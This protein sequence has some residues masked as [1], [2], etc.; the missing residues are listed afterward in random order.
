MPSLIIH[1]HFYQ[2]PREN[3]WTGIVETEPDAAPYHDWNE[4]V[5][6]EC[7]GPNAAVK[8]NPHEV[9]NNYANLSF[10]FGPT[11]LSWLEREHP[12]TYSQ[13]IAADAQSAQRHNGHGNAIAHAYNHPILPLCNDRDLNTQIR[14]GLADFRYRFGRA[15]EAMW[16]PETACNDGVLEALIEH[17]LR[18][19]ILAPQQATHV[20]NTN[21]EWQDVSVANLDTSRAYRWPHRTNNEKFIS[22]FFYDADVAHA[23]AFEQALSS[24]EALAGLMKQKIGAR[25]MLNVATDGESY[26]HHHKFGDLALAHLTAHAAI[27]RGLT[28][29]NYAEFLDR[30]PATIEVKISNGPTGQGS[31]WSCVHGVA[32]W[33]RDCG[34]HTGGEF[35]WNQAWRTPLRA[36]LD[37]LSEEAAS[38]FEQTRGDLFTDPW[39]ARDDAIHLI[40]DQ[41]ELREEFL[42]RNAARP[43]NRADQQRA[44]LFLEM[45]RHALLMYTSC[46]WFFNDISGIEPIQILKYACRAIEIMALL[47]L[48]SPRGRFLEI[49]S[50]AHSNRRELG[51]GADIYR[52]FVEPANPSFD[53]RREVMASA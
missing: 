40:L 51:N 9:V 37:F 38:A 5:Y 25:E 14:W 8:L 2:P 4:R 49:L 18:F 30:H 36:A 26:G 15:A 29:T 16:L 48:P 17:G 33:A 11:L 42:E 22:I 23:I 19:A 47:K 1:G 13:I 46:G 6:A 7:Y 44:L 53:R 20:R 12:E 27:E 10:D 3:P 32:R 34:C 39:T 43:L 50:E 45:Q 31:S 28:P 35:N 52:N 41:F 21:A 24:S